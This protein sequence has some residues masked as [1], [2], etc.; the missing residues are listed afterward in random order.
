ML[1]LR[2]ERDSPGLGYC[3]SCNQLHPWSYEKHYKRKIGWGCA[4]DLAA[5]DL[6]RT[7]IRYSTVRMAMNR[8]FY[9]PPHGIAVDDFVSLSKGS[10]LEHGIKHRAV[11]QGRIIHDELYIRTSH[12]FRHKH[13]D[14]ETL[15]Q[16]FIDNPAYIKFCPHIG[17]GNGGMAPNTAIVR[18]LDG[19]YKCSFQPGRTTTGCGFCMTDVFID[20]DFLN[21][22][23]GWLI[24]FTTYKCLGPCRDPFDTMWLSMQG[25]LMRP[26]IRPA[27]P[28]QTRVKD[29]WDSTDN[30]E[31]E[32]VDK[33]MREPF[34]RSHRLRDFT[35]ALMRA[36]VSAVAPYMP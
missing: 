1:L 33:R 31:D 34:T 27:L 24:T 23:E 8:H 14:A 29:N 16:F 32:L 10:R 30:G 18:Y 6:D 7:P 3:H 21:N 5:L 28:I 26:N 36:A 20:F 15:R 12:N 9:G 19:P 11:W 2:I 35:S 22:R 4:V 25:E 17:T 13:G